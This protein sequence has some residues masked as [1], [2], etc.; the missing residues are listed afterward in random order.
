MKDV[1][2]PKDE[3]KITAS[4]IAANAMAHAVVGAVVAQLSGQDAAAGAI[5]ASSGELAARAIMAAQYPGKTANDLTEEEK[6]SVSALSTLASGLVSGL[7][8]NS[9]ATAASGAQSGRNAV[10]NNALGAD[11]GTALGFWFGKSD[12][13]NTACKTEIAKG[14]AEGNLVVSA[15]VAGV[16]GGAMIVGATPEIVAAAK[17][18]LEGCK[19][20][21][22]ICLNN[23]GLQVAEAVTPGGVGAAGAIGVGKTVAEATVAKAEAVVANSTKN[24]T[25][26]IID[27]KKFEYLF[28]N[29]KSSEHNADRSTQLAQ[30]MNRLGLETNDNGASVLTEHLKQ[31]VNTKGNIVNTYTKGNQSFEV[32]ESLLFGPTG[33]AAKLETAFEIM[34]DGVRRFV[35]TI[36]KDGKK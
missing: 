13:C 22:T 7:A 15:G 12:E 18:A 27:P 2:I 1:T 19:A 5:G 20:A 36:P 8:G 34:P 9:T 3:S 28:G 4:D 35:T 24:A 26:A 32:R 29:V 6:Q 30:T 14:I 21:P 33:K 10:E 23:A 16:A 11:A 25:K 31:V 17:A